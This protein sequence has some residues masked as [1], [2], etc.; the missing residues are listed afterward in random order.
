MD[1]GVSIAE[2]EAKTVCFVEWEYN[3]AAAIVAGMRAGYLHPAPVWDNVL[4]FDGTHWR[5]IVDTI[6]AGYPCQPFSAA[7]KRDGENDERHL[8]PDIA[9]IIQ[10]VRPRLVFLE[11]VAGHVSLGLDTVLRD[12][13]RMGYKVA[14]GIF[15]AAETGATHK[16]ERVFILAYC[17]SFSRELHA[18]QGREGKGA[19]IIGGGGAGLAHG[20]GRQRAP[21]GGPGNAG[22][23]GGREP[24][25]RREGLADPGDGQLSQPRR[26]SERRDGAG[27]T[28]PKRGLG[29]ASGEPDGVRNRPGSVECEGHE[30][31]GTRPTKAGQESRNAISSMVDP[32]GAGL[33]GRE[34][35]PSHRNSDGPGAHGPTAQPGRPWLPTAPP[36]PNEYDGWSEVMRVAPDLAPAVSIRDVK[37]ICDRAAQMVAEG[38]MEEAEAEPVVRRMVD[39]MAQRSRSL[40]LYGNGVHPLAAA[41]AFRTLGY[42]LGLRPVDMAGSR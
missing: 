9:R 39:G 30:T 13:R 24:S 1:L 25:R 7:G 10:E 15:S 42:A 11:N 21:D 27:S 33:E 5:G 2:P 8:W 19:A 37:R 38:I 6:I 41:Y 29:D 26:R 28:S 23:E 14:A 20:S 12:L 22:P 31:T 40:K 16:R 36:R 32:G 4:T 18:G 3:A 17:E 34:Q 35:H